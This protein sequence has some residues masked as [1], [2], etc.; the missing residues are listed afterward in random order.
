MNPPLYTDAYFEL[1]SPIYIYIYTYNIRA[2]LS[3]HLYTIIWE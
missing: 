2:L 3:M 1:I